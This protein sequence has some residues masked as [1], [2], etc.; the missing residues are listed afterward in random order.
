MRRFPQYGAGAVDLPIELSRILAFCR[1]FAVDY[2]A[3]LLIDGILNVVA[4]MNTLAAF[5]FH[6]ITINCVERKIIRFS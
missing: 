5:D 6:T 3:V 2:K 1:Y 4:G